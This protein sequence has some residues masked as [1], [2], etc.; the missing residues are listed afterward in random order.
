ML[1]FFILQTC[2]I[3]TLKDR[4]SWMPFIYCIEADKALPKISAPKVLYAMCK[5]TFILLN[6]IHNGIQIEHH[7]QWY[8]NI[9]GDTYS[10]ILLFREILASVTKNYQSHS[11][12][13]LM[14]TYDS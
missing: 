6:I 11:F 13:Y 1:F 5:K 8:S 9:V 7:T 2:A 4:D 10:G 12:S 14:Y 3:H